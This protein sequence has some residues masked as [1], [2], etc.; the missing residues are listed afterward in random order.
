[1]NSRLLQV[2]LKLPVT[3]NEP[4]GR[5][6]RRTLGCICQANPEEK[7]TCPYCVTVHLVQRQGHRLLALS[8]TTTEATVRSKRRPW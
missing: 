4:T 3:N 2:T 1:M 8:S 6:A 5:R 7:L